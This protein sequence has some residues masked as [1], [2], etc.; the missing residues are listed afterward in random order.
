MFLYDNNQ[1]GA[2]NEIALGHARRML[3]ILRRMGGTVS[4]SVPSRKTA[5]SLTMG[6]IGSR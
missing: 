1:V 2:K 4:G 3:D 6:A 5:W